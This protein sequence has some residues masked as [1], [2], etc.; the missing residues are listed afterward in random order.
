MTLPSQE[1]LLSRIHYD[2][3]SGEAR[4]KLVDESYG[5]TYKKINLKA[6]SLLN[7]KKIYLDGHTLQTARVLFK[8]YYG[9]DATKPIKFRDGNNTNLSIANITSNLPSIKASSML[10]A[11]SSIPS[12]ASEIIDY[13]HHIGNFIWKSRDNTTFNTRFAGKT[14]GYL[15]SS[16]GYYIVTIYNRP[17][18]AHRVAWYLYYGIDPANYLL[19]HIDENKANNAITNLRLANYSF[20]AQ[21]SKTV[22]FIPRNNKYDSAIKVNG[23]RVNLGTYDTEAEAQAAYLSALQKLKPIYQFTESE[24]ALLD[25]LYATYPNAD[26]KLQQTC[27]NL[28][29]KALN[30]YVDAAIVQ[31]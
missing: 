10:K 21:V 3:Q 25:E 6:G 26:P 30:Y 31:S 24:Q 29:V 14:A 7:T 16:S 1:Y 5:P 11:F 8:I 27:H 20:N 28:Q 15:N 12:D 9:C 19:D 18:L 2:P 13:E 22:S 23:I 4:W 17:Y